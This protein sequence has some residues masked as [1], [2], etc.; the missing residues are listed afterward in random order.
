[1]KGLRTK[2]PHCGEQGI[3]L[4]RR[5]FVNRKSGI[6]CE[7][8]G[9]RF[10]R[11]VSWELVIGALAYLI[12]V[13]SA[14]LIV[15]FAPLIEVAATA[16]LSVLLV[17]LFI[18]YPAFIPLREDNVISRSNTPY[19]IVGT[20]ALS[21]TIIFLVPSVEMTVAIIVLLFIFLF[22]YLAFTLSREKRES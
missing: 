9:T 21:L 14:A 20:V 17:F 18:L 16:A 7:L 3:S 11:N 6:V 1:M 19:V 4:R 8:C 13:P 2:C 10:R 22:G 15:L 5:I 12:F